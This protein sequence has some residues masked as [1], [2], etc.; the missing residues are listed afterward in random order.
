MWDPSWG[1]WRVGRQCCPSWNIHQQQ[2]AWELKAPRWFP[3]VLTQQ[4]TRTL[5][6][7]VVAEFFLQVLRYPDVYT[8]VPPE[9]PLHEANMLGWVWRVYVYVYVYM[10]CICIWYVY[11]YD[12]YMFKYVCLVLLCCS[13][14]CSLETGFLSVKLMLTVSVCRM[15]RGFLGF[16]C[17]CLHPPLVVLGFQ[18]FVA[19]P[20]SLCDCRLLKFRSSCFMPSVH[21]QWATFPAPH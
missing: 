5:P 1:N 18:G 15:I 4:Q 12:M 9:H 3:Q 2:R 10:I 11:V 8:Q 6:S 20:G 21:T 13:L 14:P 17:L 16:T 7:W 19:V